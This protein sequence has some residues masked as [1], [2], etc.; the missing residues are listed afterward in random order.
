MRALHACLAGDA[1]GR[2]DQADRGLCHSAAGRAGRSGDLAPEPREAPARRRRCGGC[3][4]IHVLRDGILVPAR[5][6]QES[7]AA[8]HR[9]GADRQPQSGAPLIFLCE[10]AHPAHDPLAG[11][12]PAGAI[13]ARTKADASRSGRNPRVR[14]S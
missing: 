10:G 3:R 7:R 5:V 14:L 11:T 13:L 1:S 8:I 4:D 9:R 2:I 12:F 6:G